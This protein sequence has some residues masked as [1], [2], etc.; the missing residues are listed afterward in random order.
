METLHQTDY[1]GIVTR[2]LRMT[3]D[4]K[5]LWFFG[6]FAASS[7]GSVVNWGEEGAQNIKD[8]FLAH[9]E[10]LVLIVMGLVILWLVLL[11]MGIISKG[12]LIGSIASIDRGEPV[13]FEGAWRRGLRSFWG[14]LGIVL[15]GLLAFLV[16]SGICA[17]AVLLPIA[18][19]AAGVALAIVIGAVLLLPYLAFLFAL[20]FTIIYAE[21]TYVVRGTRV[22]E[23]LAEGWRMTRA[24]PGKS[25]VMW[26]VSFA[27]GMAFFIGLAILLLAVALPFILIGL[28]NLVL[29]LVIGIPIGV[30]IVVLASSMF[31]TYDHALWTL[32]YVD[33]VRTSEPPPVMVAAAGP[34][35]VPGAP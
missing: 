13:R 24:F 26:L 15:S 1:W 25:L 3:W 9:L 35:E 6:F 28:A 4:H 23:A 19:G 32:F 27:S 18:G 14:L 29:A 21:R 11:V 8:F 20:T 10:L 12:A 17:A 22:G 31:S 33:L 7:G 34:P 30:I 16:V 5:F 2:S